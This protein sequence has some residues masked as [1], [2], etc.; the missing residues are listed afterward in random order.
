MP[1][2][3]T[4]FDRLRPV[5]RRSFRWN[6]PEYAAQAKAIARDILRL[7]VRQGRQ[8]RTVLLP[9]AFGFE[10]DGLRQYKPVL[11]LLHRASSGT[12]TRRCRRRSGSN[13]RDRRPG[14][15][16]RRSFRCLPHLPPDWL[17]VS[18]CR[19]GALSARRRVARALLLRRHPGA[20]AFRHGQASTQPSRPPGIELISGR[21]T[22]QWPRG[23]G[24]F[25]NRRCA[26]VIPRLL[27]FVAVAKI[28]TASRQDRRCP[29]DFPSIRSSPDYYSAAL[30]LL[31]RLAWQEIMLG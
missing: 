17:N 30:T 7:L 26:P 5:A 1:P 11:L 28:A 19:D 18:A 9:A 14:N 3:A 24:G 6:R 20:A 29:G 15:D 8:P 21:E 27:G 31:A 25:A 23:V 13:L 16:R 2:T 12:I 10:Q 22:A 4:S